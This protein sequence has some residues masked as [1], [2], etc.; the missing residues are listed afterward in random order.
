MNFAKIF[1]LF[2]IILFFF[3]SCGGFKYT[4]SRD[5]PVKGS[6]RARKNI[7]EGRGAGLGGLLGKRGTNYEFSSSNPMWRA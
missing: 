3:N 2:L 5:T 7:E 4:S 6:E 1:T